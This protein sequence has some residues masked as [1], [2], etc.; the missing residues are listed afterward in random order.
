MQLVPWFC[1]I[2]RWLKE[3]QTRATRRITWPVH[4]A[5]SFPSHTSRLSLGSLPSELQPILFLPLNPAGGKGVRTRKQPGTQDVCP[6]GLGFEFGKGCEEQWRVS[7]PEFDSLVH[8][9]PA[10]NIHPHDAHLINNSLCQQ[11]VSVKCERKQTSKP[12]DSNLLI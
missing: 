6:F 8:K 9:L 1:C 5:R 2:D 3:Q 10:E 4:S 12:D 11:L 7:K